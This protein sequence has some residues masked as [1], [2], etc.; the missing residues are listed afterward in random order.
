MA[1]T[2]ADDARA[3]VGVAR[4]MFGVAVR[5]AVGAAPQHARWLVWHARRPMMHAR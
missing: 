5:V 4:T 1:R 3:M 2:T